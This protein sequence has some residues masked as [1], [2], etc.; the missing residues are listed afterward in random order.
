MRV[1]SERLLLGMLL[2][3]H[4][5]HLTSRRV[6]SNQNRAFAA[7]ADLAVDE[8]IA[9]ERVPGRGSAVVARATECSQQ[10]L[11]DF[12]LTVRRMTSHLS[13]LATERVSHI[14][15]QK[16]APPPPS[17]PLPAPPHKTTVIKSG[18][19]TYMSLKAD[20]A[21]LHGPKGC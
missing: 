14:T 2:Q 15:M 19:L 16:A 17:S 6:L 5:G 7:A 13:D 20:P 8:G 1:C 9:H 21:Q 10:F 4:H 3:S 12:C 11:F 18:E